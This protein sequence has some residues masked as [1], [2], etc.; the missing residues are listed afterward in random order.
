MMKLVLKPEGFVVL[1]FFLVVGFFGAFMYKS[2][3]FPLAA[4]GTFSY[5][6]L[7]NYH[8]AS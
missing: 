4:L 2:F 7:R 1:F 6:Q 3:S 8:S 5:S